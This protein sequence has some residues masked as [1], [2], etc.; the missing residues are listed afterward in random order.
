VKGEKNMNQSLRTNDFLTEAI[1]RY[2]DTLLRIAYTYLKN[3]SDAEDIVQEVFLKLMQ[4]RPSFD[5]EEHRKAWLIRVTINFSKNRLKTAW[6]RKTEP[7]HDVNIDYTVRENEVMNAVLQLSPKYR[8][9]ILLYYIEGYSIAEIA[10]ILEQK[11]TT[12]GSQ[13]HRARK[14]LKEKLKEDFDDAI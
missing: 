4:K 13:L 6:F 9:I 8:S 7:L 2:S 10:D 5:N 12:V 14:L 11:E 3:I 1:E